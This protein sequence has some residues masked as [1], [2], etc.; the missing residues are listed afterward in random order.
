MSFKRRR[1]LALLGLVGSVAIGGCRLPSYKVAFWEQRPD[2]YSRLEVVYRAHAAD[3]LALL[4]PAEIRQ[5]SATGCETSVRDWYRPVLTVTAPHPDGRADHALAVLS[6]EPVAD[7]PDSVRTPVV[8]RLRERRHLSQLRK[9][10]F[11]DRVGLDREH[12]PREIARM[13]I[14]QHE[15]EDLV[16]RLREEGYFEPRPEKTGSAELEVRLNQQWLTRDWPYESSLD[17]LVQQLLD[18]RASAVPEL[19]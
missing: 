18:N 5:T 1:W 2:D 8:E 15:V 3:R 13:D 17:S 9:Q 11:R 10:L 4:P 19:Q 16:G 6:L 14:S 7:C 12:G